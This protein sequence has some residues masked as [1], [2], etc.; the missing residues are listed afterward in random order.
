M[1]E[2]TLRTTG[3]PGTR[4]QD[5]IIEAAHQTKELAETLDTLQYLCSQERQHGHI[6]ELYQRIMLTRTELSEM[7]ADH[8]I[9]QRN[10]VSL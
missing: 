4:V 8:L 2:P 6:I 7:L 9:D 1:E 3:K 10:R 5:T